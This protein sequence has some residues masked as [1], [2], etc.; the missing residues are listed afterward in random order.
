MT[1]PDPRTIDV[2][3]IPR[4]KRDEVGGQRH[5][6]LLVRTTAPPADGRA[7]AKVL[8]LVARHFGVPRKSVTLLSGHHSRDKRLLI[9]DAR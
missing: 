7:N 3:V 5:G 1:A 9:S 2:R 8:E 4:A 6:R